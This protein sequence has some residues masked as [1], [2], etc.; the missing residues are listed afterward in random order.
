VSSEGRNNRIE[1][2]IAI[3]GL[4]GILG[5]AVI[6]NWGKLGREVSIP[7]HASSGGKELNRAPTERK[8]ERP[9]SSIGRG[10]TE[11]TSERTMS[12]AA[13]PPGGE[14]TGPESVAQEGE[15]KSLESN[16]QSVQESQSKQEE[17]ARQRVIEEQRRVRLAKD[18]QA[19]IAAILSGSFHGSADPD[20][21]PFTLMFSKFDQSTGQL[22]GRLISTIWLN[23]GYEVAGA[24]IGDV[25]TMET[26]GVI[27]RHH[28][29]VDPYTGCVYTLQRKDGGILEGK[30][31][32][33]E[34]TN[35]QAKL[36][37]V[38]FRIE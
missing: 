38:S 34:G 11:Q 10:M 13:I 9:P 12:M 7:P 17:D 30:M 27:G 25:L 3:I 16:A 4:I 6:S 20:W 36:G 18:R 26:V 35:C 23:Y 29:G 8:R 32:G 31:R 22:E 2:V 14:H 21:H 15:R 19:I 24:Y 1:I 28:Y 33:R 37:K 5:A